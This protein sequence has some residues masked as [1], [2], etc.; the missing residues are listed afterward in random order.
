MAKKPDVIELE[1]GNLIGQV[2]KGVKNHPYYDSLVGFGMP[3][4]A[5]CI[6][7]EVNIEGV[8]ARF[9]KKYK[10]YTLHYVGIPQ[11]DSIK[12]GARVISQGQNG[13][14]D[15]IVV[16]GSFVRW[17]ESQSTFTVMYK[18]ATHTWQMF[19]SGIHL[20]PP[21]NRAENL[22]KLAT[23]IPIARAQFEDRVIQTIGDGRPPEFKLSEQQITDFSGAYKAAEEKL[24]D[25]MKRR[26]RRQFK[27][28]NDSERLPLLKRTYP[29]APDEL[30]NIM[31]R[32][33]RASHAA[34]HYAA[35]IIGIPVGT[36]RS[37]RLYDL[38]RESRTMQPEDFS[39]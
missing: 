35:W 7:V 32:Q 16:W 39:D 3:A 11:K 14:E 37:T 30:I 6:V 24:N 25:E 4:D 19:V 34:L 27:R 33:D 21:H 20:D 10:G 8:V 26:Q 1:S 13:E 36:W 9:G 17:K 15:D 5:K 12:T 23:A 28:Y 18:A 38:L 31:K 29:D 2:F 22:K